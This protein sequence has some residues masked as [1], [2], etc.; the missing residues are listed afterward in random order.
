MYSSYMIYRS[1]SSFYKALFRHHFRYFP[2]CD[3]LKYTAAQLCRLLRKIAVSSGF[4][5][6]QCPGE[7]ILSFGIAMKIFIPSSLPVQAKSQPPK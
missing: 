6:A 3:N 4:G 1:S 2:D 5:N 7:P